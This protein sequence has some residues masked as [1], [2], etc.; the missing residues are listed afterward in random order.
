LCLGLGGEKKTRLAIGM[1]TAM[2][3]AGFMRG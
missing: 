1:A 2:A 3:M